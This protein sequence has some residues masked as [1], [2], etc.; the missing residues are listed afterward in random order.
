MLFY[1]LFQEIM[2]VSNKVFGGKFGTHITC[3]H[4]NIV[5]SQTCGKPTV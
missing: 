4:L 3:H 5:F 1:G 2:E